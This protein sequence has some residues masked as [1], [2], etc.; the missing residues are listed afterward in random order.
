MVQSVMKTG[1]VSTINP[2]KSTASLK[3][4]NSVSE[5][6]FRYCVSGTIQ[7]LRT[8]LPTKSNLMRCLFHTIQPNIHATIIFVGICITI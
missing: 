2:V 3:L 6:Q 1:N 4:E 7:M 5:N 8:A